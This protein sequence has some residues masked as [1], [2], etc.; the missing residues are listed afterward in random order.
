MQIAPDPQDEAARIQALR[1][2]QILDSG[3]EETFNDL[4]RLAAY[5]CETPVAGISLIDADRQ[6]FK[7]KVGITESETSRDISFCSHAIQQDGPF[8]VADALEDDRFK[9][10]PLVTATPHIRFY[11]GSPLVSPEGY[12]IGTL[13]VLDRTP[14]ELNLQQVAALRVIS[15]QVITLLELR[16]NLTV[17]RD[18]VAKQKKDKDALKARLRRYESK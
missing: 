13:C 14:R 12:K 7:S 18:V 5:I 8:I 4:T 10:N 3:P 1:E 17:L 16:R 2:Y 9:A 11:A 6:W 15:N